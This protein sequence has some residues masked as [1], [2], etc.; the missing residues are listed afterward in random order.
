M[1]THAR[2]DDVVVDA[3]TGPPVATR[4]PVDEGNPSALLPRRA[5]KQIAVSRHALSAETIATKLQELVAIQ[6]FLQA[7]DASP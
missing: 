1:L 6:R 2:H 4:R 5:R 7:R 3:R